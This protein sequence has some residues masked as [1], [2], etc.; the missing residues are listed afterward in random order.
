MRTWVK[1]AGMFILILT[2]LSLWI[3]ILSIIYS[4]KIF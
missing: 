1:V 3:W 2:L 4:I